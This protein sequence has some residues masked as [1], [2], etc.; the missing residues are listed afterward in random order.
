MEISYLIIGT[1]WLITL[2]VAYG[3]GLRRGYWRGVDDLQY[4]IR[5]NILNKLK[6]TLPSESD[7][8]S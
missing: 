2:Y 8:K 5:L 7:Q 4:S 6:P 1:I 3:M